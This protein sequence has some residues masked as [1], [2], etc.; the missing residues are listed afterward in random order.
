MQDELE[1]LTYQ[2]EQYKKYQH[3]YEQY[4]KNVLTITVNRNRM[5]WIRYWENVFLHYVGRYI[6]SGSHWVMAATRT[7]IDWFGHRH[8][9]G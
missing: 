5:I 2:Y 3:Q 7:T 4:K 9:Q 8:R 6:S 1:L